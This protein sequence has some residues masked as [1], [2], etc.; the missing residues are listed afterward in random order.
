YQKQHGNAVGVLQYER[1]M[2][3]GEMSPMTHDRRNASIIALN[4][5]SLLEI[6]RNVLAEMLRVPDVREV[7][8]DRY[9]ERALRDFISDD[10]IRASL[11]SDLSREENTRLIDTVARTAKLVLVAPGEV[12][13]QEGE[14]A[15]D[16]FFIYQGYIKISNRSGLLA[17]RGPSNYIGEIAMVLRDWPEAK[18]LFPNNGGTKGMR[19]A[20]CTALDT[21]ELFR[22]PGDPMRSFLNDPQ[23]IAIRNKLRERCAV[24]LN[25]G[26]KK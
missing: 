4:A 2:I 7:V 14:P 13:C 19:T 22:F 11:F 5:G 25:P 12:I 3:I 26:T 6:D 21:V 24:L 10:N 20:T 18:E 15:T 17:H 16:F 8:E 9:A 1:N 23:N